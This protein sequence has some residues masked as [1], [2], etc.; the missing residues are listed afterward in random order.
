MLSALTGT[1]HALV[2]NH[3]GALSSEESKHIPL[4]IHTLMPVHPPVCSLCVYNTGNFTA[5]HP[6]GFFAP[7][8]PSFTSH[9]FPTCL[10]TG[11]NRCTAACNALRVQV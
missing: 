2:T 5:A 10:L 6:G 8:T 7:H 1:I 4:R 9:V 11:R 3:A